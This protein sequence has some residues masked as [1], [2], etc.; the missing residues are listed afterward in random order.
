MLG[1]ASI[2]PVP[3]P[4]AAVAVA[5]K[6]A[7]AGVSEAA[8]C[9]QSRSERRRQLA[10]DGVTLAATT[11]VAA[12]VAESP[13]GDLGS[14][15]RDIAKRCGMQEPAMLSFVVE[16]PPAPHVM[17]PYRFIAE[18]EKHPTGFHLL[19]ERMP[20]PITSSGPR[21]VHVV[22]VTEENGK[23]VRVRDLFSR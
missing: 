22:E 16:E 3:A 20:E 13:G 7:F 9:R 18:T 17:L 10:I 14:T 19:V 6:F 15:L 8:T 5:Q 23:L 11:P 12:Q 21:P 1:D 2:Q 4:D